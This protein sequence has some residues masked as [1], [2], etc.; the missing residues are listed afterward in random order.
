MATATTAAMQQMPQRKNNRVVAPIII[1][2][3]ITTLFTDDCHVH[4]RASHK[5]SVELVE[6]ELLRTFV[7]LTEKVAR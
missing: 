3:I 2:H 4:F 7:P 6:L 5:R 1:H